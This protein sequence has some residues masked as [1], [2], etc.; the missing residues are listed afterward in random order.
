MKSRFLTPL[1][2][3]ELMGSVYAKLVQPFKYYSELLDKVIE[4]P[5]E[6]IFDY[7]SVPI[8]KGTSKRGGLIHDYFSRYDSI[9]IVTK[10]RAATVYLE[11]QKCRDQSIKSNWFSK[12][13]RYL[14]RNIKTLVVR[15]APGYFHRLSVMA[16]LKDIDGGI[17]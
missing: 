17:A 1:I 10:Q 12:F 3:E 9:P 6:F 16:T 5:V 2:T 11:S 14:R 13:T 15:V 4:V 8:I 7:E